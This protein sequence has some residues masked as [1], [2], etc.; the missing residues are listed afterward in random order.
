MKVVTKKD[1]CKEIMS[2]L[3]GPASANMVDT[4]GEDDCVQK[5]RDK[6]KNF[7]GDDKAKLFDGL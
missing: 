5:C 2:Q 3:F 4:M 6:V 1:K 7:L